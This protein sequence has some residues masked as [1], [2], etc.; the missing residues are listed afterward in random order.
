M[1]LCGGQKLSIDYLIFVP[2]FNHYIQKLTTL[3]KKRDT[4]GKIIWEIAPP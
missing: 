3:K 1:N 2:H 4:D